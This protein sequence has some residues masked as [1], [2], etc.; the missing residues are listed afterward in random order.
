MPKPKDMTAKPAETSP[1]FAVR[2]S[3]GSAPPDLPSQ[4]RRCPPAG[5]L[6]RPTSAKVLGLCARGNSGR[7][8]GLGG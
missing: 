7:G 8:S 6:L 1:Y 2:E 5:F 4:P 3:L